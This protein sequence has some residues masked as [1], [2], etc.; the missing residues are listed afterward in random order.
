MHPLTVQEIIVA[1]EGLN[2]NKS[3]GLDGL[4]G[5]FYRGFKDHLAPV[6]LAL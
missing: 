4:T 3:P 1:I 5:E 2:R 6:L